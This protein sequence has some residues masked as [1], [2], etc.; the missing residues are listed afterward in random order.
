MENS[1]NEFVNKVALKMNPIEEYK[2]IGV[3]YVSDNLY[4]SQEH[5]QLEYFQTGK[6]RIYFSK[7]FLVNNGYEEIEERKVRI[8]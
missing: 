2:V 4:I 7:Y 3:I 1:M 6:I 8:S 5:D